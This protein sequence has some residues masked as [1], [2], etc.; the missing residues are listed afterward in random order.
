MNIVKSA[1]Y[2]TAV[3]VFVLLS[4]ILRYAL[5]HRYYNEFISTWYNAYFYVNVLR[6]EMNI[7]FLICLREVFQQ[8]Y[9]L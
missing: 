3:F 5:W 9:Y 2:S 7:S 1:R 8:I 6:V 4:V